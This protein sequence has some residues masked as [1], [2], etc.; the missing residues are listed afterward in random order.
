[1]AM[2][3]LCRVGF[4]SVSGVAPVQCERELMFCC[5][6]EI[7]PGRSRCGRGPYPLCNLQRSLLIWG[8]NLPMRGSVAVSA[9]VG[10]FGLGSGRLGG[11]SG[12]GRSTFSGGAGQCCSGAETALG[13]AFLVWAG[14][15]SVSLSGA[16]WAWPIYGP[17]ETRPPPK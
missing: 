8:D 10:V 1:M 13:A 15:L 14:A 6:A 5:G 16:V 9:P 11:L 7:V 2:F 3:T 12:A 17:S 4:C